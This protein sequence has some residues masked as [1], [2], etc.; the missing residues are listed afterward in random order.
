MKVG[1][2]EFSFGYALT[3][4]VIRSSPTAPAGAPAFPNLVQ[5]GM[6]GYDIRID[7]PAAPLFLQFKLPELMRRG[8][9]F[10]IAQW[11]C[12][13]LSV[14]FFRISMMRRDISRQ[15]ELLIELESR[16]PS[17]VFYAAPALKNLREF[18]NAYNNAFVAQQSVFFSPA[19][20]GPLPDDKSHTLAYMA[21]AAIGNFFSEPKSINLK[22]FDQL[23]EGLRATFEHKPDLRSVA[24]EIRENVVA[25]ASPRMRQ[26]EQQIAERIRS[27]RRSG[28]ERPASFLPEESAL[29]DIL[30]AREIARVDMGVELLVAQPR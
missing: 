23:S 2:T 10:E 13:G 5:E 26:A 27:S 20:I 9:V 18:D 25:L 4:N 14:P 30:V 19:D 22:T 8:T 28:T 21:G 11:R 12:P 16:Y 1:F 17:N 24:Q 3:E 15:H 29:V 6:L 7:F